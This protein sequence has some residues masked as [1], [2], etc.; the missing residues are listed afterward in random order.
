MFKPLCL[1]NGK[2]EKLVKMKPICEREDNKNYGELF[3]AGENRVKYIYE[4]Y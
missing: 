2:W 3:N 4:S 1:N